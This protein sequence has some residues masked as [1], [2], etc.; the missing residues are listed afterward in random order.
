VLAGCESRRL[1]WH[2]P[3]GHARAWSS[4]RSIVAIS[5]N[6]MRWFLRSEICRMHVL[7]AFDWNGDDGYVR[8]ISRKRPT[9]KKIVTGHCQWK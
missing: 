3:M 1:Y 6:E 4:R 5:D 2:S 7:I 9:V 8:R